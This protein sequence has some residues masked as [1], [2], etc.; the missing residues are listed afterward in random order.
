MIVLRES[1]QLSNVIRKIIDR[2]LGPCHTNL[3]RRGSRFGR[4]AD[5]RPRW[6]LATSGRLHL[7]SDAKLVAGSEITLDVERVVTAA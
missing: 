6:R 7:S 4:R 3:D 5:L 1:H 2:P